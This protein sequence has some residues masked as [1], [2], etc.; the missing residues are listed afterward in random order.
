MYRCEVLGMV[1]GAKLM[2]NESDFIISVIIKN[3]THYFTCYKL[4][5]WKPPPK[6][7]YR[8]FLKGTNHMSNNIHYSEYSREKIE[9]SINIQQ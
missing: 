3:H 7:F 1:S 2:L 6:S 8:E 4:K 5:Q 9:S